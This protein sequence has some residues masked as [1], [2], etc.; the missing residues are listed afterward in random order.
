MTVKEEEELLYK[1]SGLY[2]TDDAGKNGVF[3]F[4]ARST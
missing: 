2:I 4:C 1:V 3:P